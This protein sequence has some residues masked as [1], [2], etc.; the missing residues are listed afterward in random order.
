MLPA[1]ERKFGLR[2]AQLTMKSVKPVLGSDV[3]TTIYFDEYGDKYCA[4]TDT[5]LKYNGGEIVNRSVT[6]TKNSITYIYSP[7]KKTG[8]KSVNKGSFNPMHADF[9][10]ITPQTMEQFGIKK[11]GEVENLG[12]SCTVYIIDNPDLQLQGRYEVWNKIPLHSTVQI[13]ESYMEMIAT[14]I[15]E[16]VEVADSLFDIPKDIEITDAINISSS[17]SVPSLSDSQ[18]I[19]LSRVN[20]LA[21]VAIKVTRAQL[22]FPQ[23]FF[24]IKNGH[25]DYWSISL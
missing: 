11:A 16:N 14:E 12:R 9:S 6:V 24:R 5:K 8:T 13:G 19:R 3:E 15:R 1:D 10:S 17:D 23:K 4:I 25:W 7:E 18:L 21:P 22:K 20:R 2:S